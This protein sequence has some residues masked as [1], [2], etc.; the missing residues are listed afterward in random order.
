MPQSCLYFGEVM[1]HRF[2][3][4]RHRFVYRVFSLLLDLDEIPALSR[5]LRVFSHNRFNLFAFHDRDHGFRDGSVA[6]PW[7]EQQ[8]RDAGI[9]CDAAKIF[10]LCFPRIF[11]YVFNPL[12]IYWCH[13]AGGVLRAIVYEVKNTFGEQHAYAL[14]VRS[15]LPG[16]AIRQ[17][18]DKD[19]YVSP[20]IDMSA[21]YEFRLEA[22]EARLSVAICECDEIGKLLV[23]THV[24]C[25]RT[26]SD[27]G[28]LRA[29]FAF[30]LMTLKIIAGIHWEALRL[31]RKGVAL[32]PRAGR[33]DTRVV[34]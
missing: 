8:L 32:V 11:G 17:S 1:H 7:V 22:P 30:P 15:A 23:A 12:T 14:P 25:R 3:P 20:F 29:F 27:G 2:R 21:C 6:R 10:V 9:V 31:W 18:A 34:R 28:L 26:L 33:D 13:D 5:R 24:G 19:F 16:D 4:V